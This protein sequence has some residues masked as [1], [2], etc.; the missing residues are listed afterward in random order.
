MLL[1]THASTEGP[2]TLVFLTQSPVESLHFCLC[3]GECKIV[4]MPLWRLNLC[5]ASP[6]EVLH[7]QILLALGC[8]ILWEFIVPLLNLQGGKP[9]VHNLH[10]SE[11]TSWDYCS[12]VGG[13][14]TRQIWA[15]FL[16]IVP[17]PTICCRFFLSSGCGLFFLRWVPA[18][19]CQCCSTTSLPWCSQRRDECMPFY[20][21]T[22]VILFALY[23]ALHV[24]SLY[25][26]VLPSGIQG[27][28]KGWR[29]SRE[30]YLFRNIKRH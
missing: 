16:E 10:D 14:P 23:F 3:F 27:N 2:P 30:I 7:N 5:F 13:S 22:L 26:W 15:W 29:R 20:Q 28:S 19:S 17:P 11:R 6:R 1:M 25:V 12:P 9:G 18:S 24:S 4:F 21:E 8:Q